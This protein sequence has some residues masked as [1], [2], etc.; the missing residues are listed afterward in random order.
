MSVLD[1]F[2]MVEGLQLQPQLEGLSPQ[3]YSTLENLSLESVEYLQ[4]IEGLHTVNYEL[5]SIEE[6]ILSLQTLETRLAE[7]QGRPPVELV[8]EPMDG[9]QAG[10]F[11]P[12]TKSIHVNMEHVINP[13]YRLY[14]IDTIAHEGQHALQSFAVEH[15]ESFPELASDIPYWEANM[16]NAYFSSKH[17]GEE[18]GEEYYH[19]QPIELN[20]WQ[21]GAQIQSLFNDGES[22]YFTDTEIE[23][24]IL[25][26]EAQSLAHKEGVLT[27]AY[28]RLKNYVD[29]AIQSG[30][31]V[32][33]IRLGV[34]SIAHQF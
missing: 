26:L 3:M 29:D 25:K 15:P 2:E 12:L 19:N 8:F 7:L 6:R 27:N 9:T 34:K 11:D 21:R 28:E 33:V 32:D 18:F 20:A 30:K 13:D 1:E 5:S 16:D 4:S 14:V 31:L 10:Y 24:G 22:L 17:I 23:Q